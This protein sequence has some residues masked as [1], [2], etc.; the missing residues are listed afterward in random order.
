MSAVMFVKTTE[1][2]HSSVQSKLDSLMASLFCFVLFQVLVLTNY[3]MI[4]QIPTGS[5]MDSYLIW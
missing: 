1:N 5:L 3:V 4:A 2:I